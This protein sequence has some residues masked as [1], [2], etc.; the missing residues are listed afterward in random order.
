MPAHG[1]GGPS[2]EQTEGALRALREVA[3]QLLE[4]ISE[5]DVRR[6][7]REVLD[8]LPDRGATL[9]FRIAE[10]Y[11]QELF[12]IQEELVRMEDGAHA[13]VA[14]VDGVIANG[15]PTGGN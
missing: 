15:R 14:Y 11:V 7:I 10:S 2:R 9:P 6:M 13:L 12:A 3:T 8:D 4:L 1:S 5:Q